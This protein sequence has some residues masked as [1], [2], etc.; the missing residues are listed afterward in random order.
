MD[1]DGRLVMAVDFWYCT[2]N[3]GE[4]QQ[5]KTTIYKG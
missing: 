4:K 3:F 2:H 5:R 1:A